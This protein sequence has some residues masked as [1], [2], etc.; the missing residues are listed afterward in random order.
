MIEKAETLIDPRL[1]KALD[2]RIL[3]N[4]QEML[5]ERTINEITVKC[6]SLTKKE[7]AEEK[8]VIWTRITKATNGI[9]M[10]P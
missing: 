3:I 9:L 5:E 6:Q 1:K 10:T 2:T 8:K 4:I 7:L